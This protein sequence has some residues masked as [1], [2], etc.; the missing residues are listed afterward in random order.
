MRRSFRK[1]SKGRKVGLTALHLGVA[2]PEVLAGFGGVG[3]GAV[4]I[5]EVLQTSPEGLERGVDPGVGPQ[6]GLVPVGKSFVSVHV[7]HDGETRGNAV[8]DKVI[9]FRNLHVPLVIVKSNKEIFNGCAGKSRWSRGA[10]GS[11]FT[12]WTLA[13][14]TVP[15]TVVLYLVFCFWLEAQKVQSITNG[16]M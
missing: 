11:R 9:G 10:R 13:K 14:N 1:T 12:F 3:L 8:P 4:R 2:L 5:A 6:G 15:I 7:W 16:L